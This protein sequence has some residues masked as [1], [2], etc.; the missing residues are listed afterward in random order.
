MRTFN[1]RE[2]EFIGIL[3]AVGNDQIVSLNTV[4][5]T[6]YFT[7]AL[8]RALII[9]NQARYAVF[10][11]KA[12]VFDDPAKK[13]E[14]L[15]DFLML[16]SLIIYLKNEGYIALFRSDTSKEQPMFFL[17]DDFVTAQPSKGS[18]VLN[19]RGFYT[20]SP[21]TIHDKDGNIIYKGVVSQGENYDVILSATTG[22]LIVN[23]HLNDVL[24]DQDGVNRSPSEPQESEKP[25]A[26]VETVPEPKIAEDNGSS[27]V[28]TE[29][30]NVEHTNEKIPHM[31]VQSINKQLILSFYA[32][33]VLLLIGGVVGFLKFAEL[34]TQM[35]VLSKNT[36]A[37]QSKTDVIPQK[38]FHTPPL[39]PQAPVAVQ[40]SVGTFYGIDI[41]HW[42]GDVAA[43]IQS[44]D[45]VTFIICK[46]TQ[47]EKGI[48]KDFTSNWELISKKK[49]IRGAYHF[50][51]AQQ[52]PGKQAEHFCNTVGKLQENDMPLIVDIEQASLPVKSKVDI[53]SLQSALLEFLQ[54]VE[55]YSQKRPMIYTD[56][57]FANNYLTGKS[58]SRYPLW[59]AEYTEKVKPV[60]PSG[61]PS[62]KIWQK[63][64]TYN[65]DSKMVDYDVYE[66]SIAGLLQ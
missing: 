28:Q 46:A 3:N 44:A 45:K 31:N 54:Y 50:Y 65:L 4:L 36:G 62:Y 32:V 43:D 64:S 18:I 29:A 11:L 33:L 22:S 8:G 42:N 48:D 25:E 60:T 13:K 56:Y 9:Q 37:M 7:E 34:K 10:F 27:D 5:E 23:S 21:G 15:E 58:F 12:E 41:S 38:A 14:E 1:K 52:D 30:A 53:K 59:I 16:I 39:E 63:S 2:K 66:G 40:D 57:S 24:Q 6:A 47:G 17:Q 49:L 51:D 55:K 19:S 35:D 61:W 26:T 20:S